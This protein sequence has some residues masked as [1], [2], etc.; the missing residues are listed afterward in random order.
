MWLKTAACCDVLQRRTQETFDS[1]NHQEASTD[2]HTLLFSR[3]AVNI[4]HHSSAFLSFSGHNGRAF[5]AQ[6][7]KFVALQHYTAEASDLDTANAVA[8]V[9][10]ESGARVQLIGL[11]RRADLKGQ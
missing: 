8:V 9:E 1:H 6:R 5:A 3:A 10:F 11:V 4:L 7:A 2:L